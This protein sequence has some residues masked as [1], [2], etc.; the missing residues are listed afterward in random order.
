M[1]HKS[2]NEMKNELNKDI[3]ECLCDKC[4]GTGSIDAGVYIAT[5][6]KK[7]DGKGKLD[8]LEFILGKKKPKLRT[9]KA[10][11]SLDT[12]EDL[13]NIFQNE[14]I[15]E[16]SKSLADEIDKEIMRSLMGVWEQNE[17]DKGE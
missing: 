5:T 10:S 2:V 4:G 9:L 3:C 7:C 14:V 12:E 16:I 15:D 6:C 13:K 11:W 8:W 17:N 1:I